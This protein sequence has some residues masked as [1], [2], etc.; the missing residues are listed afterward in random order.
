MIDHIARVREHYSAGGLNNR[1]KAALT[2]SCL[3]VNADCR[4]TRSTG[5]VPHPGH[6]R[7]RR[8]SECRR[9]VCRSIIHRISGRPSFKWRNLQ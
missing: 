2:I 8:I 5:P 4:R 9:T 3:M 6:A 7:Y 1:I